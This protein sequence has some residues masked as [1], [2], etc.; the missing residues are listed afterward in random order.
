MQKFTFPSRGM[1]PNC[2]IFLVLPI[3]PVITPDK[4]FYLQIF[5]VGPL[6]KVGGEDKR[7]WEGGYVDPSTIMVCFALVYFISAVILFAWGAGLKAFLRPH[8]VLAVV[9]GKD[10]PTVMALVWWV[11][12]LS[13]WP[14]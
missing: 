5:A 2:K 12:Y 3:I 10:F 9:A 1:I 7:Y 11:C 6:G 14:P 8:R 4:Y 13:L